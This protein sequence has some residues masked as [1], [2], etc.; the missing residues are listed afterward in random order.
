MAIVVVRLLTARL[1]E[2]A[3]CHAVSFA[4]SPCDAYLVDTFLAPGAWGLA[5]GASLRAE[6]GDNVKAVAIGQCGRCLEGVL[7]AGPHG[8]QSPYD[9]LSD[10]WVSHL[11]LVLVP[12][13]LLEVRSVAPRPIWQDVGACHGLVAGALVS[14]VAIGAGPSIAVFAL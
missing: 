7:G 11:G 3:P 4:L 1:V 5:R 13:V 9:E 14:R 8:L 12:A 2:V 6:G 10:L